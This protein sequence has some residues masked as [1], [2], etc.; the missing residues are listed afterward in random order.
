MEKR[1]EK[2]KLKLH[3]DIIFHLLDWQK[4]KNSTTHSVGDDVGKQALLYIADGNPNCYNPS[5]GYMGNTPQI[6]YVLSFQPS[7]PTFRNLS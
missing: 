7:K 5:E 6:T 3:R 2:F 4:L 1:H